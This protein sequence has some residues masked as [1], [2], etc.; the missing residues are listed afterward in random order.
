MPV[1]VEYMLARIKVNPTKS[2][3][4]KWTFNPSQINPSTSPDALRIPATAA[5]H[6]Q[7]KMAVVS[8]FDAV[9]RQISSKYATGS[10]QS[11]MPMIIPT[12]ATIQNPSTVAILKI[13]RPKDPKINNRNG[14]KLI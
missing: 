13:A 1:A 14:I 11:H 12:I 9:P 2:P 8:R 6:S 4:V 5:D 7:Q 10:L 3:P